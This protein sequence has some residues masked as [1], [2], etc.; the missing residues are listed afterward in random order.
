MTVLDREIDQ[1]ARAA[2]RSAGNSRAPSCSAWLEDDVRRLRH[3][4]QRDKDHRGS[5]DARV[6]AHWLATTGLLRLAQFLDDFQIVARLSTR[7]TP[8]PSLQ[9]NRM[10]T[11]RSGELGIHT[12]GV[13]DLRP[14]VLPWL[15]HTKWWKDR[16]RR[17]VLTSNPYCA[18]DELERLL[19]EW[20]DEH[21]LRVDVRPDLDFYS[22]D[23]E[24][25]PLVV[26]RRRE[27]P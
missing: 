20:A 9:R 5:D 13:R 6:R 12:C 10:T 14:G 17:L 16:G 23:G 26:W 3:E 27:E 7:G 2:W 15:D 25:T 22:H 8:I 4:A 21:G 18:P 11:D 1:I 19:P 24:S